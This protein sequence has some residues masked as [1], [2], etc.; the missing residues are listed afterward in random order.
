MKPFWK[1]LLIILV[2]GA[3]G[4]YYWWK[5]QPGKAGEAAPASEKS[6]KAERKGG[7]RR[8]AGGPVSVETV[9]VTRQSMPIVVDAVGTIEPEQSVVVRPQVNGAVQAVLFKEGDYVKRG[10]VLFRIDPRQMQSAVEQFQATVTRDQAQL[11]QAREQESRLRPLMEKDYITRQEFDVAATQVKAL[12]ATSDANRAVLNQAK[13]QLSYAEISAPLAGRTGNLSV[14]AGNLVTAGNA[15][16]TLVIINSTQ[17]IL[18]SLSVPQRQMEEIRRYWNTPDLKVQIKTNPSG[19]VMGE[20]PLIFMD[21]TVNTQ[22]GTI[23]LK[24]R[25]KNEKEELW[26][27]QFVS[28][29]ITLTIEKDVIVLPDAAVQ[30]G[31]DRPFVFVVKDGKATMQPVQVA[32][33]VDNLVVIAK[34]LEGNEQVVINVPPTLADGAA[35]QLRDGRG[36]DG[37]GERTGGK[38]KREAKGDESSKGDGKKSTE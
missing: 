11:A 15:P 19:P 24:A 16:A 3:G 38:G 12:E 10:Q 27:G 35:V 33:Q 5:T 17:P 26:P 34:G 37:K 23:L 9:T 31:Q 36:S 28:A 29:R 6:A 8:G 22:T 30:P 4:G 20:G 21:N 14:K 2:L 25:L 32:R 7:G 18:A 1:S 13:L